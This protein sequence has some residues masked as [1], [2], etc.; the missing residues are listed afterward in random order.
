MIVAIDIV[1][2]ERSDGT[3]KMLLT[4]PIRRWKIL[5]SKYVTMLFFISLIPAGV[6]RIKTE[7]INDIVPTTIATNQ[8]SPYA[9]KMYCHCGIRCTKFVF[10]VSLSMTNPVKTGKFHPEYPNTSPDNM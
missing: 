7:T 2:G 9:I 3:M 10:N 5:L 8:A 4:R 6:L 1:S